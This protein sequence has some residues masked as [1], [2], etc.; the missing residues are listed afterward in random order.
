M[1]KCVWDENNALATKHQRYV[2]KERPKKFGHKIKLISKKRFRSCG[3]EISSVDKKW[4]NIKCLDWSIF[5]LRVF[6][7][8]KSD[9]KSI[10]L[11]VLI[12]RFHGPPIIK[13]LSVLN[14]TINVTLYTIFE[15]TNSF[16]HERGQ[17]VTSV[18]RRFRI[19]SIQ[20]H[21]KGKCILSLVSFWL[22]IRTHKWNVLH[23]SAFSEKLK[24]IC[25]RI[26]RELGQKKFLCAAQVIEYSSTAPHML[27]TYHVEKQ[28]RQK[29]KI[30]RSIFMHICSCFR[31]TKFSRLKPDV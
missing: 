31:T 29:T 9:S 24:N 27:I 6:S 20:V 18:G 28:D 23:V 14:V 8:L 13:C 2:Q 22:D 10:F 17:N 1:H 26:Y 5:L 7:K 3:S 21:I 4:L 12:I 19:I 16:I 25:V 30:Y 11:C 15:S